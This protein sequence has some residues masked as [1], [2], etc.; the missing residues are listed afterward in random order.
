VEALPHQGL[1][2]N[3]YAWSSSPLRRYVDLINQWQLLR[4]VQGQEPAWPADGGGLS[5]VA[6]SFETA[7]DTY[8][9][10]QRNMERFWSL[11]WL[12]QNEVKQ[13]HVTMLR[14]GSG[15]V[16]GTPLIV[17][18]HGASELT[19]GTQAVVDLG[20]PDLWELTVSCHY[21]GLA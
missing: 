14:E 21:R 15:R 2:V 7:Y 1:G 10:F 3:Q 19:P 8:N 13:T 5:E 11:R 16:T 18:V 4:Q 12:I 20:Q 9:E 6:R 17:K